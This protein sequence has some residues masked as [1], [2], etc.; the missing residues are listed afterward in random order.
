MAFILSS[1]PRILFSV[2]VIP[3]YKYSILWFSLATRV[4]TILE[5]FCETANYLHGLI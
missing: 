1:S 5:I 4:H 3:F 2:Q